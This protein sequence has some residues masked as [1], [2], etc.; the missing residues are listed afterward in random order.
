MNTEIKKEQDKEIAIGISACLLGAKV[1]FDGGHKRNSYI[2]GL[3]SEHFTFVAYCPEV[4]IG[5]SIPRE[6]IRLV[7][8]NGNIRVL[9]TH[10]PDNEFTDQLKT[11]GEKVAG[12]ID[13]LSGFVFKKDSP[14]CGMERV[15][16]YAENG[17]PEKK[18]TG[19]FAEEIM[20]QNP[21]LPVEE[22]GRLNDPVLRE[23]F[24]NRVYVYARWQN[25]LQSGLTKYRLIE[26]HTRHKYL[27]LAHN[28]QEYRELGKSLSSVNKADVV[29]F[30]SE[31]INRVMMVLRHRASRKMHVNVLQHLLGFLRSHLDTEDR[32]EI[33]DTIKAYSKGEY[34][35]VVP[36]TLLQHHFRR[37]PH[38]FVNQQV[39]LNPH[40][41]ELML[42]NSI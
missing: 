30:S 2:D 17:M 3:L 35:L 7:D 10:N 4:A 18:G 5:M 29:K 37:N 33:L 23:N 16:V 9:G 25:L 26:F 34:P 38:P 12:S 40:P 15:K 27:M 20:K 36:I 8:D 41:R 28:Q 31:Y 11:Y 39:Y 42:R 13:H 1:R 22:E 14:S 32:A 24:I 21:L 6:P 19:L